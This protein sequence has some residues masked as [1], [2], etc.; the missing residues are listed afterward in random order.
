MKAKGT[1]ICAQTGLFKDNA[2]V[3]PPITRHFR[4]SAPAPRTRSHQHWP[5]C[6]AA[7]HEHIQ[8]PS[9]VR[10]EVLQRPDPP[11]KGIIQQFRQ[12]RCFPT[13]QG[14][15]SS[16]PA[17]LRFQAPHHGHNNRMSDET[18][19]VRLCNHQSGWP[20]PDHP[21]DRHQP[22][23]K[24][25][26]PRARSG[27]SQESPGYLDNDLTAFGYAACRPQNM[28]KLVFLHR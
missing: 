3:L 28:L 6:S 24:P 16:C 4:G 25:E 11:E 12:Y 14:A 5:A 27:T 15:F 18:G 20:C 9:P 8:S 23:A 26:A 2:I 22:P 7:S 19:R 13:E 17:T 10:Q 21:T 1:F